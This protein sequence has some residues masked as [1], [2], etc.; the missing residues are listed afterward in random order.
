MDIVAS[1]QN[2]ANDAPEGGG[3]SAAW[4]VLGAVV[5]V[6]MEVGLINGLSNAKSEKQRPTEQKERDAKVAAF[7]AMTPVQHI[8]HAEAD[9]KPGATIDAIAEGLRHVN[10]IPDSCTGIG[11]GEVNREEAGDRAER[12]DGKAG[13]S[14]RAR[15]ARQTVAI[16]PSHGRDEA[17]EVQLAQRRLRQHNDS[18]F[19]DSKR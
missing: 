2:R 18:Y 7:N 1:P 12:H 15:K 11:Q 17:G 14:S 16:R 8:E 13:G 19:C 4:I 3:I 5:L 6:V 9:L 10:A